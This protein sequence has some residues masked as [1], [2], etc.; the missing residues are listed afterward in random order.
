[1]SRDERG[2]KKSGYVRGSSEEV[3]STQIDSFL[4][5]GSAFRRTDDQVFAADGRLLDAADSLGDF[6]L[7]GLDALDLAR[8]ILLVRDLGVRD[9]R[10][11]RPKATVQTRLV[12]VGAPAAARAGRRLRLPS[13]CRRPGSS[14]RRAQIRRDDVAIDQTAG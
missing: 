14:P 7:F 11:V 9:P 8:Q 4:K 3:E 6:L 5:H 10:R 12:P 1:M 13:R 2:N